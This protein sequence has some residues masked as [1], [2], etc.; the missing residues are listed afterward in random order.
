MSSKEVLKQLAEHAKVLDKPN[1]GKNAF[2]ILFTFKNYGA[3]RTIT[4]NVWKKYYEKPN[5]CDCFWIVTRVRNKTR[6]CI[7]LLVL[8][9][10]IE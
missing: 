6:V 8:I 3:G 9:S 2:D 5:Q 7:H 10:F 1:K 4:R